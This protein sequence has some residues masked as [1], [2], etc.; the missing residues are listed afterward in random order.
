MYIGCVGTGWRSG[1]GD[2]FEL[3][4]WNAMVKFVG[5]EQVPRW[6]MIEWA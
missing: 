1:G 3:C 4:C 6:Q 2:V 5:G